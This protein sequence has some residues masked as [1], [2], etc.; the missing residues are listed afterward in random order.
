[1]GPRDTLI[2][3]TSSIS[4]G[5][6][7]ISLATGSLTAGSYRLFARTLDTDGQWSSA[8]STQL[9]VAAQATYG[10]NVTTAVPVA[11]G[12]SAQG[13]LTG[14]SGTNYFK[15]QLVAGQKYTFQTVLG[16]LYDSV[17]T[18]LGTN[19]QMVIAQNDDMAPGNRA[20][21]ITWQATGQRHVLFGREQLPRLSAGLIYSVHQWAVALDAYG[22]QYT[23]L[24]PVARPQRRD[25]LGDAAVG[26]RRG[27]SV[28]QLFWRGYGFCVELVSGA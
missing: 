17:L 16:S 9:T 5:Q 6:A 15:V 18:L 11:I 27:G 19:G 23:I 22:C 26:C 4:G 12:S 25:P 2:G 21:R 13:N 28:V 24:R 8:V 14:C 3:T 7:T 20:S 1:M 10:T